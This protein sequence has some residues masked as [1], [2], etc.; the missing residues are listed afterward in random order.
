MGLQQ[1]HECKKDVS[2]EAKLCPNCGAPVKKPTSI[3]TKIGVGLLLF[4][5]LLIFVGIMLAP[6]NKTPTT[7]TPTAPPIKEGSQVA[8]D[9]QIYRELEVCMNYAKKYENDDKLEF[10]RLSGNCILGLKKYN[11]KQAAKAFK[12]YFDY[13]SR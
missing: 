12:E 11:K 9:A 2:S 5:I 10:Q 1:C 4:F 8:T 7:P 6:G 13:Y 3:T